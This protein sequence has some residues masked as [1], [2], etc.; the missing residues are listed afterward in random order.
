M[1]A[2]S[3]EYAYRRAALVVW[4]QSNSVSIMA[5]GGI[6]GAIEY[7]ASKCAR[8]RDESGSKANTDTLVAHLVDAWIEDRRWFPSQKH[9]ALQDMLE[10]LHETANPALTTRFLES[11][12]VRVYAGSENDALI[13][14]AA[15]VGPDGMRRFLPV[16]ARENLRKHPAGVV[17]VVWRLTERYW[18]RG[19]GGWTSALQDVASAVFG[20][21]AG[22]LEPVVDG[23]VPSW[24]RPEPRN[25][26]AEAVCDLFSVGWTIGLEPQALEACRLI[27]EHP[28]QVT[29]DRVLPK[30]LG[31]LKERSREFRNAATYGAL[32][33]RASEALL[34][35]S[36]S[37]PEKPRDWHI[38]ARFQCDCKG[39]RQLQAFCE[40]PTDTIVRIAVAQSV[41]QHLRDVIKGQ[42]LD[43]S[44]QTERRGRPYS[45][46][47]TKNRASFNRR[48]AEYE[49]DLVQIKLLVNSAP[50]PESSGAVS[51]DLA[52]LRKTIG[53][54][55]L[56]TNRIS[57]PSVPD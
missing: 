3:V 29:P 52:R 39:C 46:I 43:I 21:L 54:P 24:N 26:D 38:D 11:V 51:E 36:S 55:A 37:H 57:R 9:P 27:S 41:R 17:D 40:D 28:Q 50:D 16:F 10:L 4:P 56:P 12:V 32:W 14:A 33:L 22:T 20:A 23:S 45:L 15:Q 44:Y 5:Q 7:V 48:L 8:I 30:A 13:E 53:L 42:N 31:A 25:L 18:A 35:R 6:S 49:E 19:D 1:L 2:V 34:A 47:C